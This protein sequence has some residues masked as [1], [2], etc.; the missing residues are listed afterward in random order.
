MINI[1]RGLRHQGRGPGLPWS[2][3]SYLSISWSPAHRGRLA[4]RNAFV[5][6]WLRQGWVGRVC[7]GGRE[8]LGDFLV[9]LCVPCLVRGR[10]TVW[11]L[12]NG[13]VV[14]HNPVL[15][16]WGQFRPLSSA[17]PDAENPAKWKRI[18]ARTTVLYALTGVP[19]VFVGSLFDQTL[20]H[21]TGLTISSRF[22][23]ICL[24]ELSPFVWVPLSEVPKNVSIGSAW[25][26]FNTWRQASHCL[27]EFFSFSGRVTSGPSIEV[28]INSIF[29]QKMCEKH[30]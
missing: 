5:W 3:L 29:I 16:A 26:F 30:L 13:E 12:V 27:P 8:H 2:P 17:F 4:G 19:P 28:S 15:L 21:L 25:Q 18:L 6:L 1:R 24:L 9:C 20:L 10:R 7:L 23:E 22:W 11:P 14:F